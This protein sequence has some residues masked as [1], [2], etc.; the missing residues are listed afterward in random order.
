M[1]R[2]TRPGLGC[3]FPCPPRIGRARTAGVCLGW[4][5]ARRSRH[6][7]MVVIV[8]P[9]SVD[10]E[11]LSDPSRL[12][13]VDDQRPSACPLCNQPAQRPGKRL[14]IVGHGTYLRQLLGRACARKALVIR[15]RRFLCR[16]CSTTISVLPDALLPRRWY[17]GGV[18]FVALTLSL[19]RGVPAAEVRRRLS[20]PGE[21][22][23]WKTL[24][25]WQRQLL[26]PLWS[27]VAPQLGFAGRG[28]AGDRVQRTDRLRRL[29]ALH[30]A[31]GRSPTVEIER[32]ACAL[33]TGTAHT[34][35]ESWE[36]CRGR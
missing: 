8:S 33:A 16:G 23:G 1:S 26:A 9:F 27:W 4:N 10:V 25:R 7:K 6:T 31:T 35:T 18:I 30:G 2:S 17:A 34:R 5:H 22:P 36:I 14:G 3:G 24:D 21:T 12:P 20:E 32:V 11:D 13:S 19:L 29:L 15:V 28:Q